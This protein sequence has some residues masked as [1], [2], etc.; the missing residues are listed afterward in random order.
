[1]KLKEKLPR[2]LLIID[3]EAIIIL[4]LLVLVLQNNNIYISYYDNIIMNYN[5]SLWVRRSL[6]VS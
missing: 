4:I 3:A 5:K 2:H 1:M 6:K